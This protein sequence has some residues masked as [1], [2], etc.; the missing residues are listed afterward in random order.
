[1]SGFTPFA[2][3]DINAGRS[4]R[5][6]RVRKGKQT[7]TISVPCSVGGSVCF[8]RPG[9]DGQGSRFVAAFRLVP[10]EKISDDVVVF[11][12]DGSTLNGLRRDEE[13]IDAVRPLLKSGSRVSLGK[14]WLSITVGNAKAR[15]SKDEIC[16][17][18]TVVATRLESL[19]GASANESANIGQLSLPYVVLSYAS[20]IALGLGFAFSRQSLMPL[21]IAECALALTLVLACLMLLLTIPIHLR[22]QALGG[23]VAST[24]VGAAVMGSICLGSAS[25]LIANTY[26]GERFLQPEGLT[27]S[28]I[29]VITRG[30]HSS[31]TLVLDEPS[32]RI[33]AGTYVGRLPIAC[34]DVHYRENLH[35]RSYYIDINP[36]LFGARFV[37]AIRTTDN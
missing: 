30:K 11:G 9:P 34:S 1:M 21:R 36:G 35:S 24:V 19:I 37:Q 29:I 31:C 17:Y 16:R 22:K 6:V 28:G 13:F 5:D 10:P 4:P 2:D 33:V 18:L 7:T 25:A 3:S 12:I 15:D 32:A 23:P 20:G 8:M 14:N 27:A 26:V